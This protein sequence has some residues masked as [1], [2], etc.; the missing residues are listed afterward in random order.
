MSP[1]PLKAITPTVVRDNTQP[2]VQH[3]SQGGLVSSDIPMISLTH[4]YLKAHEYTLLNKERTKEYT[5]HCINRSTISR[6]RRWS[7]FIWPSL[8]HT[9]NTASSF[10]PLSTKKAMRE[11][12]LLCDKKFRELGLFNL[13]RDGFAV[14][15]LQSSHTCEEVIQKTQLGSSQ[16]C[17]WELEKQQV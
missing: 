5:L 12:H 17:M 10:E 11:E 7:S 4:S 6:L 8:D 1:S 13:R 14:A 9:Y 3:S 15:K 2:K 16:W